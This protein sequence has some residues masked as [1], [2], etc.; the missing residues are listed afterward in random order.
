MLYSQKRRR[1]SQIEGGEWW[2]MEE[3]LQ[4]LLKSHADESVIKNV[5]LPQLERIGFNSFADLVDMEYKDLD[6]EGI[7]IIIYNY[8]YI[9]YIYI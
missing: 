3:I 5:V 4:F 9:I 8:I 2:R 1:E 6:I 7:W